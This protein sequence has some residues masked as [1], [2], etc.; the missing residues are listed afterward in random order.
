M[1]TGTGI[2]FTY[3]KSMYELNKEYAAIKLE[4]QDIATL[5]S[6]TEE[7]DNKKQILKQRK[8]RLF[9]ILELSN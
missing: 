9:L 5:K 7:R 8:P 3:I 2:T 1:E 4:G 6:L